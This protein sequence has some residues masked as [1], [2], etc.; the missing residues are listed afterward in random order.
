VSCGKNINSSG[1]HVKPVDTYVLEEYTCG[2]NQGCQLLQVY[3]GANTFEIVCKI[4]IRDVGNYVPAQ[5]HRRSN[6]VGVF[7]VCNE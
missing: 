5:I 7:W 4:N 3:E 1:S 6:G 2:Y